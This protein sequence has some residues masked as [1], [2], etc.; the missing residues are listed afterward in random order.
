MSYETIIKVI[1]DIGIIAGT[2]SGITQVLINIKTLKGKKKKQKR[3]PPTKKKRRK[4][5]K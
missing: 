1:S 5:K 4:N 2:L 3:R